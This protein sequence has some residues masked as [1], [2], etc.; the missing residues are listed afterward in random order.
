MGEIAVPD[1]TAA[2]TPEDG[3][4]SPAWW[5][6]A[7]ERRDFLQ[8][9]AAHDEP[10][11]PLD[12]W[13]RDRWDV[14]DALVLTPG[15]A[16]HGFTRFLLDQET[17]FRLRCRGFSPTIEVAA[18]LLSEHRRPGDI[19]PLW[20]AV[21]TSFGTWCGLSRRFLL[22]CGGRSAR[23]PASP[24]PATDSATT[25]WDTFTNSRQR[26]TAT[27]PRSSPD[28]AGTAP[29]RSASRTWPWGGTMTE[30]RAR[31]T[32]FRRAG[33]GVD[34]VAPAPKPSWSRC[35]PAVRRFPVSAI[36]GSCRIGRRLPGSVLRG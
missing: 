2:H 4:L 22:A 6:E 15:P 25:C 35:L 3:T 16:G 20:Q 10:G 14:L 17:R 34:L 11:L 13:W 30:K 27:S 9:E 21:T 32:R 5:T 23:S 29:R 7:P 36:F 28:A 26:P 1:E 24:A 12:R 31:G 33:D 19:R 18:L 8:F